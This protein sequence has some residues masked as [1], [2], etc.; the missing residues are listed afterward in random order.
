MKNYGGGEISDARDNIFKNKKRNAII[1]R[2]YS[3]MFFLKQSL[4]GLFMNGLMTATSIFIL[5][6]CLILMGC[7]GLLI[8]NININL[9]RIDDFNKIVIFIGKEYESEEELE[10]IKNEVDSLENTKKWQFISKDAAL[11]KFKELYGE[12]NS[13]L[14]E[15]YDDELEQDLNKD[16]PMRN[17]IE[18]E[19]KDIEKI[20]SYVY[21]LND[22]EGVEKVRNQVEVAEFIHNLRSVIMLVLIWFLVILFVIAIA[23]ILNT[24]KLSVNSRKNEIMIMRYIGA[25]NFFIVFPF[26]LEGI[27]IGTV[28]ALT[29]YGLQWYI[30][31]VA[32]NG[33]LRM[34]A[35][36]TVASFS[37]I[38]ILLFLIFL[39]T[40]VLSGLIGSSL[41]LHKYL[42]V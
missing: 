7:F 16:N 2:K 32:T 20:R 36:I 17:S 30:Y 38:N 28:S 1:M 13:M 40:G 10:R 22:I 24:V 5:M 4:S 26:L 6:S 9:N 35:G 42:K 21:Q 33:I 29:A 41:S 31:G 12:S 3:G 8:Y 19:Y 15:I 23:I 14:F 11:N 27:I 25:T 18:I 37:D 39:F 34:E